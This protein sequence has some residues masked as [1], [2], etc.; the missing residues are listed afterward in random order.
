MLKKNSGLNGIPVPQLLKVVCITA[1]IIDVSYLSP[2]FK[3]EIFHIITCNINL[4]WQQYDK[5][6]STIERPKRVKDCVTLV[7]QVKKLFTLL[8]P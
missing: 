7:K 1:M 5:G 6:Y 4:A 3:Y 2:Q 8:K